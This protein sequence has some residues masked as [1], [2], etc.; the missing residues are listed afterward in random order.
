MI[1]VYRM[2]GAKKDKYVRKLEKMIDHLEELK[3]CLEHCE[4]D[5]E[6]EE[7]YRK[8]GGSRGRYRHNKDYDEFDD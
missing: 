3:D 5:E 1:T 2:T 6:M 7:H 8:G 4:R